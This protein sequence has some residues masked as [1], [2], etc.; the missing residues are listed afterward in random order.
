MKEEEL[1]S[2][3]EVVLDEP[4]QYG[5]IFKSASITYYRDFL[6]IKTTNNNNSEDTTIFSLKDIIKFRT[7]K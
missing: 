2:S 5:K 1:F 3:V 4:L 6:I 7:I